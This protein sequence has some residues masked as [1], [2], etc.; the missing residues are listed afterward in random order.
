MVVQWR[1]K[2]KQEFNVINNWYWLDAAGFWLFCRVLCFD[3]IRRMMA[4]G[5]DAAA[6]GNG[7]VVGNK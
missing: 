3:G 6:E 4:V 1:S 2:L 5:G 7:V